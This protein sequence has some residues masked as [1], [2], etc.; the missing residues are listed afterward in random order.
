MLSIK[1]IKNI[2][3]INHITNTKKNVRNEFHIEKFFQLN[4]SNKPSN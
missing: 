2:S 4:K 3:L 1:K